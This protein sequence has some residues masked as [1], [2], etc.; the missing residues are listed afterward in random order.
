[1]AA[2]LYFWQRRRYALA[3]SLRDGVN[4]APDEPYVCL[5][6]YFIE[7]PTSRDCPN[8]GPKL[9]KRHVFTL[10]GVQEGEGGCTR[11]T[12][13]AR[14]AAGAETQFFTQAKGA[15]CPPFAARHVLYAPTLNALMCA[16][17]DA[18]ERKKLAK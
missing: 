18:S 10:T 14:H 3:R 1:M 16:V 12:G 11:E 8:R 4:F 13:A 15:H 17:T 2:Q 7:M 9:S 5:S 6:N